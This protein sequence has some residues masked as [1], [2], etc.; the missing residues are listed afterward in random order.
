MSKVFMVSSDEKFSGEFAHKLRVK[1]F[2]RIPVY[3]G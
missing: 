1:G 3:A 2:S